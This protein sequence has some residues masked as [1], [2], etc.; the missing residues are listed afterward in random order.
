MNSQSF[1]SLWYVRALVIIIL[2][3]IALA[4]VAYTKL[5]WR[6]SVYG[7]Y[8]LPSI[9]VRGEGE[10]LAKPDIGSFSFSVQAEGD[11]AGAAQTAS[12]EKINAILAFLTE[13]GVEDK[14]V[15]TSGYY[16]NPKYRYDTRI[17]PANSYCPPGD[18]ILDG[19]E[20]MESVTVKVRDIDQSGNL[21]SGVGER[22][23][24]NI[25]GL[26]FTIDDDSTLKD[27]ARAAA[28]ADAK[29]RAKAIAKEM[30]VSLGRV[31]GYYEEADYMPYYGGGDMAMSAVRNEASVTPSLPAGENLTRS[32]VNVTFEIR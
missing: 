31:T 6:E 19:Y 27:E 20:V 32:I 23:A 16:L 22:G 29:E 2:V 21:I 3:A 5:T 11:D 1:I 7:Q 30:G 24:T 28:I 4:L 14:D 26:S 9:S 17:C 10:V 8:G 12:A 15:K 25:S 13:A 18:P